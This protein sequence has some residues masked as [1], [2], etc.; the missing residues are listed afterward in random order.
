MMSFIGLKLGSVAGAIAS[1]LATFGPL[2]ALYYF[3]YRSCERFRAM[4]WQRIVRR[5][6]APLTVGLV[7]PGG[8]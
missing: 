2:C 4:A 5:V 3:S 6:L 8:S 1:A 7:I